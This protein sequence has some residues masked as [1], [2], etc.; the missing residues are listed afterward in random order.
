[1]IYKAFLHHVCISLF[2]GYA[3]ESA[4]TLR[5]NYFATY[6]DEWLA[7]ASQYDEKGWIFI[8]QSS[9]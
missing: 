5:E 1:M 4:V 7:T 8:Y 6:E 3:H 9:K 2:T